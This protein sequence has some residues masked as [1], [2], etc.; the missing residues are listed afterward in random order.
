SEILKQLDPSFFN[1]TTPIN[2]R[3]F[4][5]L[6]A[7]HPNRPFISYLLNSLKSG[8]RFNFKYRMTTTI[9]GNLSSIEIDPTSFSTYIQSKIEQG[10]M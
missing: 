9:Q 1:V 5:H 2:I 8:F 3:A 7:E 4:E 10:R 6:T